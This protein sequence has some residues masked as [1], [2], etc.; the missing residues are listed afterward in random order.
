MLKISIIGSIVGVLSGILG[1]GGN[2]IILKVLSL[3]FHPDEAIAT[4]SMMA[5]IT[6]IT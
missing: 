2:V 3:E 1:I 6:A 4:T 5:G